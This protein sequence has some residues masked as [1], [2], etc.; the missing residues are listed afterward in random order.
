MKLPARSKRVAAAAAV[1]AV[2]SA[3]TLTSCSSS[4][5]PAASSSTSVPGIAD[6]HGPKPTI[7]LV[8]GAWA[9]AAGWTPVVTELQQAGFRVE[10]PPNPLRGLTSDAAYLSSVLHRINGPVVLVGHS[11]GG[12]VISNAATG[13][14]QVKALVYI[15]AFVP[16]QG[17]SLAS[18]NS[19]DQGKKIP[20]VPANPSPYP[21]DGTPPGTE[22][23]IDPAQ[24]PSVF[25]DGKLPA[26]QQQA[27][28][29]E[30]RPL[31]IAAATEPSGAPAW[32]TIPSW[33]L[34]ARQDRAIAP[35][36]ERFMATRAGAHTVEAD[37]PHLIMATDPDA[38]TTLIEQA[39]VATGR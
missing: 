13:D 17:E 37:G 3:L 5:T 27:L 2:A 24:Y 39:A 7:V 34:V 11:Y 12:A 16:D 36:L 9:D 22:L 26:E 38:V 14:S 31:S 19:S 21:Q 28:A 8:H 10:A 18:L 32:K 6:W 35:D 29:V 30:Q 20:A 15:A 33:Y 25:L 23:T 1:L 4:H